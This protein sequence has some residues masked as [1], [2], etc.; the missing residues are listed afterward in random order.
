[1]NKMPKIEDDKFEEDLEELED[2]EDDEDIPEEDL[3]EELEELPKQ[4][5]RKGKPLG[6]FKKKPISSSKTTQQIKQ[7]GLKQLPRPVSKE[8][9]EQ[10]VKRRYAIIAPQPIR[11]V[12]A[13]AEEVIGEGDYAVLQALTDILERLERIENTIGSMIE[14]S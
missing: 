4:S 12:D 6:T 8:Q 3:D 9:E 13:E 2:D 11:I 7:P 10:E 5:Q 1:M 14:Q